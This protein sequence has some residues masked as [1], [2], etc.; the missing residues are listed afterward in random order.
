VPQSRTRP[1]RTLRQENAERTLDDYLNSEAWNLGVDLAEFLLE[2]WRLRTLF[3]ELRL[4]RLPIGQNERSGGFTM[5]SAYRS[6]L[7]TVPVLPPVRVVLSAGGGAPSL[8]SP[9]NSEVR[10]EPVNEW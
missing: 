9:S 5:V 8:T 4:D 2:E 10:D 7:L 6:T 3:T 1:F